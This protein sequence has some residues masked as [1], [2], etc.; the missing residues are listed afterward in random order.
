MHIRFE[1]LFFKKTVTFVGLKIHSF[2]LFKGFPHILSY[3]KD[4]KS[5][6]PA[7]DCDRRQSSRRAMKKIIDKIRDDY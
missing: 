4:L 5:K 1:E 6:L 3:L 2:K 7:T